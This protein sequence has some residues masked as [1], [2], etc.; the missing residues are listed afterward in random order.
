MCVC[1]Y[2]HSR[3]RRITQY[4]LVKHPR[5]LFV[6]DAIETMQNILILIAV[7]NKLT[8]RVNSFSRHAPLT[9]TACR[10]EHPGCDGLLGRYLLTQRHHLKG[11]SHSCGD[12]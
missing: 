2:T 10:T 5:K 12:G 6:G 3:E 1:V 8:L 9:A 11:P 7:S 4:I